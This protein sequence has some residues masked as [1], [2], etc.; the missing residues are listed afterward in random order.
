[1]FLVKNYQIRRWVIMSEIQKKNKDRDWDRHNRI[2]HLL[3][4]RQVTVTELADAIGEAVTHTSAC[5]WGKPGRKNKRIE[6]KI[7]AFLGK[8]R[9]I[10]FDEDG[11]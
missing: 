8:D 6:I 1:M 7:A 5:I 10:L 9:G 3:Q 11:E 4:A 2:F